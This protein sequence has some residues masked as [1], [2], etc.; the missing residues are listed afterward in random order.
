MNNLNIKKGDKVVVLAGADKGK[1]GIVLSANPTG[2]T[3]KVEGVNVITKHV[4]PQGAKEQGGIKKEAGNINVSNVQVLCSAC[5]KATRAK[6]GVNAE[7]KKV[8][9]CG[10]CGAVLDTKVASVKAKKEKKEKAPKA[11]KERKSKS[12]STTAENN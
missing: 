3:V 8:R 7:G 5:D 1:V 6:A 2:N 9:L 10:K 4:K 11:K 12:A